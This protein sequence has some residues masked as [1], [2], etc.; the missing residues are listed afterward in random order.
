MCLGDSQEFSVG[1]IVTGQVRKIILDECAL[2]L[3]RWGELTIRILQMTTV[4]ILS[5]IQQLTLL[6]SVFMR[7]F[8]LW[9]FVLIC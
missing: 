8:W 4:M 3:A 7:S 5:T 1:D 2:V 9:S 6:S